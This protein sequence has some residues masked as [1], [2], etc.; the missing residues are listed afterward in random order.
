MWLRIIMVA[1]VAASSSLATAT[2]PMPLMVDKPVCALVRDSYCIIDGD[3]EM[4]TRRRSNSDLIR[5]RIKYGEDG[6]N[7]IVTELGRCKDTISGRPLISS[8]NRSRS[9]VTLFFRLNQ[10]CIIRV[11]FPDH[12][13]DAIARGIGI[14]LTQIQMCMRTPCEGPRLAAL[15]GRRALGWP[16]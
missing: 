10:T 1:I 3:G 13:R 16:D 11:S 9:R 14:A 2:Q 6:E 7:V 12:N 15:I 5:I 8:M 4:S